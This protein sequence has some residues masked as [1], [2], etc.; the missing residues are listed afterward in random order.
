MGFLDKIRHQKLLT[1]SLLLFTL[2]IGILIGTL[3]TTGVNAAK[4]QVAAPDATPITIPAAVKAPNNQFVELAKR[5]EGSVVNISTEYTPKVGSARKRA[6]PAPDEEDEE[7]DMDL[8]RRFFGNRAPDGSVPPRA[9]KRSATGSGFV[10]DR[11]GYILT[12]NHV[13]EK[14]DSIKVKIP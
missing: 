14:A 4:A 1:I 2:S 8:F 5:M 6:Q 9:F 10:V 11:N 13:I 3:V 7:E 12:N